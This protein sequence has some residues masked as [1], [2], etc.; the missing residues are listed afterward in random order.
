MSQRT[1]MRLH[2]I[3]GS[4]TAIHGV[5]SEP[6]V[7]SAIAADNMLVVMG[8]VAGAIKRI[9][10]AP[11]FTEQNAGVFTHATGSFS[12]QL[13]VAGMLDVDG[14]FDAQGAANLQSTLTVGGVV[15]I[16]SSADIQGALNLQSSITVA[17]VSD[18][19][20]ALDVQGA[21][22]MQSTLVVTGAANFLNTMG[23]TG[24]V[25]MGSTLAL[26][27]NADFNG[28]LDVSGSSDLHGAVKA[29]GTLEVDGLATVSGVV[30]E[31]LTTGRV[32][33]VGASD[34]LVDDAQITHSAGQ[35]TVSGST[36]SKD[37]SIVRD[38]T[39]GKDLSAIS[40]SFSGDLTVTGD[41][42][43]NGTTTTINS[44]VVS[45]DD[46]ALEL[47]ATASPTDGTAD[48]GGIILKGATDHTILWR[49][50]QDA[51]E[52]S[53]H[54]V[55]DGAKDLGLTGDRWTNLWLSGNADVDGTADIQGTLTLQAGV[56]VAGAAA[57]NGLVDVNAGMSASFIKIDGD[58]AQRLYI[59]DA[60]G[61]VKDEAKLTFDG[62]ELLVDAH[63]E[64]SG[65]ADLKSTLTVASGA[66]FKQTL[67]V[68]GAADFLSTMDI[69][70]AVQMDSTLSVDGQATFSAAINL[71]QAA[72]QS[73]LKTGGDLYMSASADLRL[74]AGGDVKFVDQHRAAS[75]WSD[76]EGIKLAASAAEWSNF[77]ATFGS[78][79]SLLAALVGGGSGGKFVEAVDYTGTIVSASLLPGADGVSDFSAKWP[80][81]VE[82]RVLKTD[83]F[84][85]GQLMIS[86]S[87]MDYAID[88]VGNITFTFSLV[89]DDMVVVKIG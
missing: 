39:V 71:D 18:L 19:N 46:K 81:I 16:N 53:E 41:L 70:G 68:S 72:D 43:I 73:I 25:Q 85:N 78:E 22:G 60:D 4:L 40:G 62:S 56:T 45:V 51:W 17:G 7:P 29:Y 1:Q 9:T 55:P 15:D 21:V 79:V 87:G 65:A 76:A 74:Q 57:F 89:P 80:S 26:T 50:S 48:G 2:A 77:E 38:L 82:P 63:L 44:T 24:A 59:V 61:S 88:S 28:N 6:A 75:T 42:I 37:V 12:G 84:V 3:T 83:V 31:D 86:G 67:I 27:D 20:G 69:V 35:L 47:G 49:D 54:L 13:N 33:L 64:V 34:R 23:I 10:G 11:S 52:F 14:A 36:F 32:A 5:S 66:D 30:V 58:V 8:Q